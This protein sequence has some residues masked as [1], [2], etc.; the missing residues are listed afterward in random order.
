MVRTWLFAV[1]IS[2]IVSGACG[3]MDQDGTEL[4]S[5]QLGQHQACLGDPDGQEGWVYCGTAYKDYGT[6]DLCSGYTQTWR[7]N[8]C[9]ARAH[10]VCQYGDGGSGVGCHDQTPFVSAVCQS[11]YTLR[12][13]SNCHMLM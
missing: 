6:I 4:P 3:G 9:S 11:A 1:A 2:A 10:E 5:R 13:T 12:C 7:N 8:Y